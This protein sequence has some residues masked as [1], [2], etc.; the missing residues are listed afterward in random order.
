MNHKLI[1]NLCKKLLDFSPEK[2]I[3]TIFSKILKNLIRLTES[4]AGMFFIEYKPEEK[5]RLNYFS[6]VPSDLKK[7][8]KSD[9]KNSFLLKILNEKSNDILIDSTNNIKKFIEAR[10]FKNKN[11]LI[12]PLNITKIRKLSGGIE[13]ISRRIFTREVI[14]DLLEI[15]KL[16]EMF[17]LNYITSFTTKEKLEEF[18]KLME[19]SVILNSTLNIDLLLSRIISE[20]RK[21]MESEGCSLMLRDPE[22]EELIFKTVHGKKSQKI[23]EFRIPAGKGI[24]GWIV[25]H[26]KPVIVDDVSKDPRFYAETDIKSGFKTKTLLGVPLIAKGEVIGVIEAVNKKAGRKFTESDKEFFIALASQAAIAIQNAQYYSELRNLF[27]SIV[28]SLTAAID[29][30]DPY[31]RGHSERVTKYSVMLAKA[32]KLS[33]QEIEKVQLAGLLHDIGKIGIDE[34]ILQKPARLTPEEYKEIQKHPVIGESIMK[35]I[36]ALK[37]V[38][39]GIRN[40]HERWDGRGYP[41]KL[42]GQRIPL[43]GRIIALADTYDAITSD[44][45]Y[46]KGASSKYALEEIIRCSGSQFDP[47]LARIFVKTVKYNKDQSINIGVIL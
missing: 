34:K 40:H 5:I 22:T 37:D 29:A 14:K 25:K 32:M 45:P 19:V 42:K 3:E 35:H 8:L 2:N 20:A 33:S 18:S 39:P 44:R 9:L 43:L 24:A 38:L 15:K 27:L 30:K 13:L 26:K 41:D 47:E 12:I 31:T 6:S 23:K 7:S 16:I 28:R 1:L 21:V 11:I 10:Y 4:D 36:N 46:R 17:L